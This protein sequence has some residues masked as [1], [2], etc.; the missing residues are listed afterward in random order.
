MKTKI[1]SFSALFFLLLL[2][3]APEKA[4]Q[5]SI[6]LRD[7][8]VGADAVYAS[9]DRMAFFQ[10]IGSSKQLRVVVPVKFSFAYLVERDQRPRLRDAEGNVCWLSFKGTLNRLLP[11]NNGFRVEW[12]NVTVDS[13]W[14]KEF[15]VAKRTGALS[16]QSDC[17][18]LATK[19]HAAYANKMGIASDWTFMI[20][21]YFG[22]EGRIEVQ[23][24]N[25]FIFDWCDPTWGAPITMNLENNSVTFPFED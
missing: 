4:S 11:E 2:G 16:P 6:A 19:T 14:D 5:A 15:P 8:P 18:E 24:P 10:S 9:K 17:Q 7:N 20:P 1:S 3:C 13:L 23:H 12:R 21:S 22:A 25:C